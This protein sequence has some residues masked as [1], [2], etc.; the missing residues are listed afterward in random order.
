M[1]ADEQV[2]RSV[3]A[4]LESTR[5]ASP[6][7]DVEREKSL[8]V[9]DESKGRSPSASHSPDR[10]SSSPKRS[11][12]V[13]SS[14][15]RHSPAAVDLQGIQSAAESPTTT[16]KRSPTQ[17]APTVSLEEQEVLEHSVTDMN[18]ADTNVE[19][20]AQ[21]NQDK[22]PETSDE[23]LARAFDVDMGDDIDYT[24]YADPE[25]MGS[26]R[27]AS[28]P[29]E[30][31]ETANEEDSETTNEEE[32]AFNVDMGDD[33]QNDRETSLGRITDEEISARAK[34]IAFT[35]QT[36]DVHK[37]MAS[38]LGNLHVNALHQLTSEAAR[39][40]R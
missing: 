36:K 34:D 1:V 22:R 31:S 4:T 24:N 8:S 28:V 16:P 9:V 38:K 19:N 12:S 21:E 18:I 10:K 5:N 39:S 2:R 27:E 13:T 30:V 40:A 25:E 20:D 37:L 32:R 35:F 6:L 29:N 14:T 15:S 23:A 3:S 17:R 33:E 7:V 26:Y 11:P